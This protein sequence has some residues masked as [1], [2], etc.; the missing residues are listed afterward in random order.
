MS[1]CG[2]NNLLGKHLSNTYCLPDIVLS[3]EVSKISM[4]FLCAFGTFTFLE[5]KKEEEGE[6]RI[7]KGEQLML[8]H[9][10]Q[11]VQAGTLGR[12]CQEVVMNTGSLELSFEIQVGFS[13]QMEETLR[14]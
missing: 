10:S 13:S 8:P 14:F 2:H 6:G 11:E 1:F 9:A 4:V 7:D 5:K 3:S 12:E